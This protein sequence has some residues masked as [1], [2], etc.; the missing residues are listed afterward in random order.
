[1]RDNKLD[2]EG[3]PE[4]AGY[5]LIAVAAAADAAPPAATRS[6]PPSACWSSLPSLQLLTVITLYL[7]LSE[8]KDLVTGTVDR[9]FRIKV[10]ILILKQFILNYYK[11]GKHRK[12]DSITLYWYN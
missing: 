6:S 5:S 8:D 9:P 7:S 11:K 3:L 12:K 1:M 2:L 4:S 10:E